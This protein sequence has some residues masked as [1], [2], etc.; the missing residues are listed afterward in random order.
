MS[1]LQIINTRATSLSIKDAIEKYGEI[2]IL[3]KLGKNISEEYASLTY[4]L[5]HIV[6]L[7]VDSFSNM[8]FHS[9]AVM[10]RYDDKIAVFARKINLSD[11]QSTI[12][13]LKTAV[14]DNKV[15]PIYELNKPF[16]S[17]KFKKLSGLTHEMIIDILSCD[18]I[19]VAYNKNN[20]V[21]GCVSEKQKHRIDMV[22]QYLTDASNAKTPE[23][24]LFYM[25]KAAEVLNK[26][27]EE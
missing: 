11:L 1:K 16:K 10:Q 12:S 8:L 23:V 6:S 14:V 22:L 18:M 15:I 9:E 2:Q 13:K 24:M 26:N 17:G 7:D 20:D 19:I 25:N 3:T 27:M 21:M 4:D 5:Y